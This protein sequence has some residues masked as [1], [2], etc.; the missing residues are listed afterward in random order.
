MIAMLEIANSLQERSITMH[1]SF[2]WLIVGTSLCL[3]ELVLPT[4]LI[5]VFLGLAA[6]GI[7]LLVL[8]LPIPIALQILLWVIVSGGLAWLSQR[9]IPK[10]SAID[11]SHTEAQSLTE[12]APGQAGRVLYEGSSWRAK[13]GDESSHIVPNQ[14]LHVIGREGTTLL[15]VPMYQLEEH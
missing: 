9:F 15:V 11:F 14:P 13:C 10:R 8:F 5:A 12:I 7:A 2:L 1:P 6:I 3:V 4:A